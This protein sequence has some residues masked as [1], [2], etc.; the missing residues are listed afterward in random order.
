MEESGV[1]LLGDG[2]TFIICH[3][4]FSL[5]HP[6]TPGQAGTPEDRTGLPLV[7]CESGHGCCF[8]AVVVQS[9]SR[10]SHFSSSVDCSPPGSSVCG[11]LQAR[12]LEWVAISFSRDLP[13]PQIKPTS[14]ALA[15]RFFTTEPRGKPQFNIL[16]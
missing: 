14:L 13:N 12:I 2:R 1:L 8:K 5:S 15:G 6:L 4:A 10:V 9:L 3:L 11:I 16:Y 7:S